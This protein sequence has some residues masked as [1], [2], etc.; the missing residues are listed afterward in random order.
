MAE[1]MLNPLG[2]CVAPAATSAAPGDGSA[3]D[4][5]DA[6]LVAGARRGDTAACFRIWSKYAPFVS[7]LVRGYFGPRAERDDLAQEVFL[8]VFS[9]IDEVRDPAALR[10][11]I[12]GIC[13]G[14]VRNMSRRARIR[15][16]LRLSSSASEEE[17]EPEIAVPGIEDEARQVLRHLWR[18]LDTASTEDRSLFVARYVEKMEMTDIALAHDFSIATAK[19]RV[20]RMTARVAA[21]MRRDPVLADYAAKLFNKKGG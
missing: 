21:K 4:D 10:G 3:A 16:I 2:Q 19:R 14:V 15:A 8:R 1:P 20:A 18:L 9:R 11:F 6:A 13:L 7:R 12:A 17:P 5:G